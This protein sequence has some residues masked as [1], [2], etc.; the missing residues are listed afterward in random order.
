MVEFLFTYAALLFINLIMFSFWQIGIKYPTTQFEQNCKD[1]YKPYMVV[2]FYTIPFS[3][4]IYFYVLVD[5]LKSIKIKKL[6]SNNP[7][8]EIKNVKYNSYNKIEYSTLE[9]K[10]DIECKVSFEYIE[11]LLKGIKGEEI[12]NGELSNVLL[13]APLP[14][15]CTLDEFKIMLINNRL[16][17]LNGY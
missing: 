8:I 2:L 5:F 1:N 14:L 17:S 11:P 13:K 16:D 3:F 7:T 6:L 10:S 4:I 15:R 12:V 9:I